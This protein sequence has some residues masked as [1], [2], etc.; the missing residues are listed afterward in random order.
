[1]GLFREE[2]LAISESK[3]RAKED[4]DE[5]MIYIDARDLHYN[6]DDLFDN[7]PVFEYPIM[8]Y[9]TNTN[10]RRLWKII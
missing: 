3:Q 1:M 7:T 6:R 5:T 4:S 9:N 2:R 8:N 10:K